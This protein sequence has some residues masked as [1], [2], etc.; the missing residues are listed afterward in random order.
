MKSLYP[1]HQLKFVTTRDMASF[2]VIQARDR[3]AHRFFVVF[4]GFQ[5]VV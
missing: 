4:A 2:R 5:L 3:F 1:S